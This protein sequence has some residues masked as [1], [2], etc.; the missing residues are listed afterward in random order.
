MAA[1]HKPAICLTA[2]KANC[3][4][5]CIKGN[6]VNRS[7]E[8][9]LPLY[10]ALVRDHLEYCIQTWSPQY[11]RDMNLLDHAQRGATKVIQGMEHLFCEDK[12]RELG[13]FNLGKR[14]L[15]GDLMVAFLYP[16]GDIRKK[17]TDFYQDLLQ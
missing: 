8:M 7:R 14:S 9:I 15:Q 1:G 13:L 5:G 16:K 17:G 10:S 11:R 12:M 3:I 4:L 6:M 2:Q